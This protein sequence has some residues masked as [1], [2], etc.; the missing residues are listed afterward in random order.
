MIDLTSKKGIFM[1]KPNLFH[2]ATSEL[3]QDAFIIYLLNWANPYYK[4]SDPQLHACAVKF[5]NDLIEKTNNKAIPHI[6]SIKTRKQFE[7]IDIVCEIND[8]HVL[9]IE[10]KKNAIEGR[11]QLQTYSK[12]ASEKFEGRIPIQIYLK[13]GN[14]SSTKNVQKNGFTP[15][16]RKDI[17]K[18]LN[19]YSGNNHIIEDFKWFWNSY[20]E[21]FK[22]YLIESFKNWKGVHWYGFFDALQDLLGGNYG[23]VNNPTSGFIGHWL[24]PHKIFSGP[25]ESH[26]NIKIQLEEK[27][28]CYKIYLGDRENDEGAKNWT[29]SNRKKIH[30]LIKNELRMQGINGHKP[31]RFGS[32]KFVTVCKIND[33]IKFQK[34]NSELMDFE[35]T[36]VTIQKADQVAR[37]VAEKLSA[38]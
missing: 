24:Q 10:D 35:A 19:E 16:L 8:S 6:H 34:N 7:F 25:N 37:V 31:T 30:I 29:K 9:I 15:Y 13:T 22:S 32:G 14:Q 17:L 11:N 27:N 33:Y 20:E 2:Y 38:M 23:K 5:I 36:I 28:L 4:N 12:I 26:G 1:T 3:S 21:K 18:I